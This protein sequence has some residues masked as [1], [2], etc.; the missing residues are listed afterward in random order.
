MLSTQRPLLTSSQFQGEVPTYS[1]PRDKEEDR[2]HDDPIL[3]QFK[4]RKISGSR[5]KT[6]SSLQMHLASRCR[7]GAGR[8]HLAHVNKT[9]E[10]ALISSG[11][12]TANMCHDTYIYSYSNC[13]MSKRIISLSQ[14]IKGQLVTRN[15]RLGHFFPALLRYNIHLA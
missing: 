13:T 4:S 1:N 12:S 3:S 15:F 5:G 10:C 8:K 2:I 14:F 7:C 6:A 9:G 11:V